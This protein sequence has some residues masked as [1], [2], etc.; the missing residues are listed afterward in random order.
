M[1]DHGMIIWSE[2]M[3]TE[4]EKAKAFYAARWASPSTSSTTRKG[5]TGWRWW[6]ESR[7][8]AIMDMTARPD[9][10][11]GWFTCISESMTSMRG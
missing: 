1:T 3:T 2:L 4:V 10:P 11:T 6:A 5:N 9:G 8:G 7:P